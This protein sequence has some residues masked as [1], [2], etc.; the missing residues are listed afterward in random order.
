MIRQSGSGFIT[1]PLIQGK[2]LTEEQYRS[3]S[4]EQL[5]DIEE[6]STTLEEKVLA[7]T[8]ELRKLEKETKQTLEELDNKV[9]LTAAGYH[10]DELK[11][12][13]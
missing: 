12:E 10:I 4:E 8:N 13:R 5:Q 6:K 3:L 9:A 11:T 7:F 2:P 1:I